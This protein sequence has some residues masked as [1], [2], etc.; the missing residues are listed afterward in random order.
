MKIFVK[1]MLNNISY[2]VELSDHVIEEIV[3]SL[4]Y[5]SYDAGAYIFKPGMYL[6]EIL[7]LVRGELE[8]SVTITDKNL[9]TYKRKAG[10][11]GMEPECGEKKIYQKKYR[12]T[13]RFR[14]YAYNL[15]S[16]PDMIPLFGFGGVVG[17]MER[18]E[19]TSDYMQ[20]IVIDYLTPGTVLNHMVALVENKTML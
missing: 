1:Q 12:L 20:E 9:H 7:F 13:K 19:T 10:W 15:K 18:E 4:S 6:D 16:R 3:Y 5:E 17:S 11:I 14:D 8:L 2:F